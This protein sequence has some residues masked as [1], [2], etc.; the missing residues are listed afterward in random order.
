MT[1]IATD[2]LRVVVGLGKTGYSCVRHLVAQGYVV[3]VMDCKEKPALADN[4]RA[5]FPKVATYFG[6]YNEAA[7]LSAHEIILSPG[8]PLNTPEIQCAI[9]QGISVTG[10]IDLFMRAYDGLVIAI[11]GS[12]GKSTVTEL[13]GEMARHQGLQVG[14]GG[15]IGTPALDLLGT[16]LDLVVLELSSFQLETATSLKGHVATVLNISEDHM[17]RYEDLQGY[18][19]AKHRIFRHANVVVANRDD[20]LTHPL[21]G[22]ASKLSW[23]SLNDSLL[24]GFCAP[25][26]DA[27][28]RVICFGKEAWLFE[29]ELKI[30]GAHNVLNALAALGLGEAAG[31]GRQAMVKALKTFPGLPHRCQWVATLEGIDFINDSKAT[32]VGAALAAID[33]LQIDGQ[34][35]LVLILGG[36]GKGADFTPMV[37]VAMKSC[38]HLVLLGVAATEMAAVFAGIPQTQVA[39]MAEAVSAAHKIAD[40]G[41]TVLLAPACAS[42][43][44]FDGFEHRGRVFEAAVRAL[45]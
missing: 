34:K 12:N 18:M 36:V 26:N 38:K 17:D 11:T 6:G 10:D 43:D 4:L 39:S 21:I 31:L 40:A 33:G 1:F 30:K 29:G 37:P 22:S 3:A 24:K 32:N 20:V 45:P 35:N 8:V 16:D 5:E 23:Y 13:V 7:L 27:G 44:M 41:D 2:S 19:S 25:R 9:A 28:E 14:V 15:N 42:F